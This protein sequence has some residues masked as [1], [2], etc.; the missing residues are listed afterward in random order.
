[1]TTLCT[2]YL[3]KGLDELWL[4]LKAAI[5]ESTTKACS[6]KK[7]SVK[8][9]HSYW[10]SEE[11]KAVVKEKKI[12]WKMFCM[13]RSQDKYQQYK[14][15]RNKIKVAVR[16]AKRKEEWKEFSHPLMLIIERIY[17]EVFRQEIRGTKE[18]FQ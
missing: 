7:V 16:E 11:L 5:L 13:E 10:W 6:V 18:R 17:I 2:T 8:R 1:M 15:A 4:K 9:K 12:L 14:V 3:E